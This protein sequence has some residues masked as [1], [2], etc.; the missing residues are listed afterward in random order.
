MFSCPQ[1]SALQTYEFPLAEATDR[2]NT[3]AATPVTS[4]DL[5]EGLKFLEDEKKLAAP[6]MVDI[7]DAKR[8]ITAAKGAR[9]KAKKAAQ[10]DES[11]ED[12]ES[13]DTEA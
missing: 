10:A 5:Q 1:V 3:R 2:V 7:K 6:M 8:R 12:L 11:E 4:F 9:P 13:N